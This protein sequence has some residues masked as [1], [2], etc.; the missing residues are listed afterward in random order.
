[1]QMHN[2]P[3]P[4]LMLQEIYIA[5]L[6]TTVTAAAARLKVSRKHLS[7]VLHGHAAVTAEPAVRLELAF[8]KSATSWLRHQ[9]DYDLWQLR[10]RRTT[11]GV[12]RVWP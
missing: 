10:D 5:G 12:E 6:H 7:R 1:M 2:P 4:G 3:H 11:L 8:G 9:A